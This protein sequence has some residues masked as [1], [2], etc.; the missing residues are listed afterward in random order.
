MESRTLLIRLVKS[1][2]FRTPLWRFLLPVM[3]FDKSIA[4][5]SF[6]TDAIKS[7]QA[8]GAVL[9]IGV[10]GGGT[11]IVINKFMAEESINRPFYAIDT[12]YG[13]TKDDV[14]FE[15]KQRGKTD[16]RGY[17]SNS[18]DWYTKTLIAHGIHNARVIQA[19]AK[20]LD[21][22]KFAPVAFC[23]LDIDL[24]NPI[25]SVLP[26][27][28]D[29]LAPGGMIVVDDCN[30]ADSPYDGAGQAYRE[31]CASRGIAAEIVHDNLGIIRKR[32]SC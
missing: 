16:R 8:D 18:K 9:E 12:F 6:I 14:D 2:Y 23:F 29:V 15:R 7:V 11:S 32:G 26:R 17:R 24:Y 4:H 25:A 13:F 30:P 31:F 19:D 22:T 10:G 28:H 5:L 21:Y 27:L 3:K 20:Q 1:A